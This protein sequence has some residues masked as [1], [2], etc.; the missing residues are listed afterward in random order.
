MDLDQLAQEMFAQEQDMKK[1]LDEYRKVVRTAAK[2]SSWQENLPLVSQ[3]VTVK[4]QWS[5]EVENDVLQQRN[6]KQARVSE[7]YMNG[8]NQNNTFALL[9]LLAEASK[10]SG[11]SV[12]RQFAVD[13]QKSG[14]PQKY[15]ELD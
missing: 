8:P 14:L 13:L 10:K 12:P 5:S 3:D 1:K 15:Q 4:R 11:V 2:A 7:L 9:K 6:I